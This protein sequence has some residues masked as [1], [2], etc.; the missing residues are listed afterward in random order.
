MKNRRTLLSIAIIGA[1]SAAAPITFGNGRHRITDPYQ[2]DRR[3]RRRMKSPAKRL[4]DDAQKQR[5]KGRQS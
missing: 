3:H 1:I 2:Q 4:L 5:S